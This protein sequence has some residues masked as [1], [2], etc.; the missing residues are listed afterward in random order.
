MAVDRTGLHKI[1]AGDAALQDQE[2]LA[3]EAAQA[4]VFATKQG[5]DWSDVIRAGYG[6]V[7]KATLSSQFLGNRIRRRHSS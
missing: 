6:A 7:P 3:K 5:T 4:I 1:V 2:S